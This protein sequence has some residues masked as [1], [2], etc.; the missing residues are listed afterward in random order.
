MQPDVLACQRKPELSQD[1]TPKC[2]T[3]RLNAFTLLDLFNLMVLLAVL[4]AIFLPALARSRRPAARVNCV[5][6]LKQV[7]LAFK[8]WALDNGDH[9]PMSVSLTNGGTMERVPRGVVFPHFQVM[10]NE[11]STPKILL[12][13]NDSARTA[14]I[15][16]NR[17]LGDVRISYFLN[18]AAQEGTD[19][20]A[21]LLLAGDRNLTNQ[22]GVGAKLLILQTNANIGWGKDIHSYRGYLLFVD[23]SV[24]Q[25]LNGYVVRAGTNYLAIP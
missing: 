19:V 17:G 21:S 12:C 16:F 20:D 24:N 11:L 2:S 5:N 25:F 10:S 14:A 8:C 9:F 1:M 3:S 13:P 22:P 15:D 7:G 4:A 6:N 23:G 18:V